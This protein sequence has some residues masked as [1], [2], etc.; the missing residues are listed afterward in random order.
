MRKRP[1][2][3]GRDERLIFMQGLPS[4]QNTSVVDLQTTLK[5]LAD[6]KQALTSVQCGFAEPA[7]TKETL[8]V[9]P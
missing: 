1:T 2:S 3:E 8:K 6:D 5:Y 9:V 7:D 4:G